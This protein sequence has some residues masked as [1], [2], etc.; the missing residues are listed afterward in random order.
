[1]ENN[2]K[3]FKGIVIALAVIILILLTIGITI[4]VIKDKFE[5]ES[6]YEQ[7]VNQITKI[8]Y[9]EREEALNE[10]VEDGMINVCYSTSAIFDG[11][12]SQSF[13]VQNSINNHYAIIFE[14]I[15]ESG[16]T[17]YTSKKIEPGYELNQIELLKELKKGSHDC[18]IKVGYAQ[19]GNISSVFP[20]TVVVM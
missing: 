14:I 2:K 9:S 13:N 12:V 1:M 11:K 10:I 6:E 3:V 19:E 15:D 18:Q 16:D 7:Q 17:I 8:D 20:L 4:F 5:K